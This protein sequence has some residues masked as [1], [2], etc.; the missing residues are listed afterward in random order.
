M[1]KNYKVV[2]IN[3]SPH[4]GMGNTSQLLAMLK[5]SLEPQGLE[6]EEI[7]L[8]RH[9]I[10]YCT[11][12]ATC[13]EKP[14]CWIQDDYGAVA[15]KA[16][17]A[18]AVILASPT[19]VRHVTAQMKTFIDRSVGYGHRPRGTWKPGLAV[20]VSAGWGETTV[21]EYLATHLR[22]FGAF[23][24][25]QLTAIAVGPG[26]FLGREA[27]VARAADLARD[28]AA[29]VKEGR[30]YPATDRDLDFWNFMGGLTKV[31][32]EFMKADY[33][34]WQKLGLYES[35]EAYMGQSRTQVPH[36]AEMRAAWIKCLMES[37]RP[38]GAAAAPEAPAAAPPPRPLTVHEMVAAMPQAFKPAVAGD[39]AATYQFE[40]S[41]AETFTAYIQIANG[42]ASYHEGPAPKADVIVRAPA[43]VWRAVMLG[44]VDGAQALMRGKYQVEGNMSLLLKL[45]AMFT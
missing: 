10:E 4:E 3:G 13:M 42:Q 35:F 22:M 41:G 18:D 17:E 14:A 7:F 45:K 26:E 43:D 21:A 8:G 9:R 36:N 37:H 15:K 23:A 16:Q 25:G 24:V 2:A 39:L 31:N 19:Y 40:I 5:E 1:S 28:L 6:L 38:R 11:G 29:A 33:E 34:H 27:V 30:R 20:S 32:R 12:C 44:E